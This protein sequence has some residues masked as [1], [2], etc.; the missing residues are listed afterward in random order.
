[1]ALR[2]IFRSIARRLNY[3]RVPHVTYHA[4]GLVTSSKYAPFM[5]D[6]R[7]MSSYRRAIKSG[8]MI[9]GE[10]NVDLHI[11]WRVAV[12]IWAAQ[13]ACHLPGDFVECGVNTG[14]LSL[15]ICDYI[16]FNRTGK[17]FFLFDTY[18]GIPEAQM[19]ESE[20]TMKLVSNTKYPDCYEVAKANFE[21]FPNVKLVR[22]VVPES[23]TTVDI[24]SVSYLSLDMNISYPEREAI[25]YFWPRM[26]PG[27]LVVL[28][29]Y[30][31]ET[32]EEQRHTMDEFAKK[33][34]VSILAMPTGQGL[35]IKP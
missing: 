24:D 29:D 18:A 35:I 20:R 22:G 11:E 13:H 25:E 28:D 14:I 26:S 27:A 17:R 33:Q 15:A 9:G 19:S 10:L 16:D 21:P 2:E 5:H 23:L 32:Y 6:R 31:W 30:G 34:G 3:V 4:D 12:A 8:H 7:F 1:M